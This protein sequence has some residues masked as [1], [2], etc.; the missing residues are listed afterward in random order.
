MVFI[1]LIVVFLV[2]SLLVFHDYYYYCYIIII[3]T[4]NTIIRI[5]TVTLRVHT[6]L[7]QKG[8]TA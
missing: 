4:V 2:L 8:L 1:F 7:C 3:A 6:D 5:C